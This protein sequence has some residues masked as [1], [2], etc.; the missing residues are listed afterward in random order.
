VE[1]GIDPQQVGDL[2]NSINNGTSPDGNASVQPLVNGWMSQAIAC[3]IDTN[4]LNSLNSDL[5]WAQDQI[6]M[7]RRRQSLAVNMLAQNYSLGS[8][9]GS[10]MVGAGAAGLGRF[11]TIAA[12]EKAG[13]KEAE[14]ANN[15]LIS[16]Q[17]LIRQ[18]E[19]NGN[20]PDYCRALFQSLSLSELLE[21]SGDAAEDDSRAD[22]HALATALATA[23]RNGYRLSDGIEF[24]VLEL[25]VP[26]LSEAT[27]PPQ[28]MA[29]L[30]SY[31]MEP[32]YYPWA[33]EVFNALAADPVASS[34]FLK[35]Y[36]KDIPF[37]LSQ[38]EHSGLPDGIANVFYNVVK[39]GTLGD[40]GIN[41]EL[42]NAAT[43]SLVMAYDAN[44][45]AHS[46]RPQ[47][48]ALYDQIVSANWDS[49]QHAI[50]DPAPVAGPGQINLSA[51][52]WQA[53]IS[54]GMQNS[55]A[56]AHLLAFAVQQAYQLESKNLNNPADLHAA[57]VIQGF[58]GQTAL[59]TY[60]QM[61]S[62]EASGTAA[63][64]T[65][66]SSQLSA[67]ASTG[68]DV[69][70]DPQHAASVVAGDAIKDMASVIAGQWA[71]SSSPP[72]LKPPQIPGWRG[73]WT[74]AAGWEYQA[75][76]N[77]GDPQKYEQ[78][79]CPGRPFLDNS[80]NLVSNANISQREAYNAWLQDPALAQKISTPQ[81]F[82]ATDN[83]RLDGEDEAGKGSS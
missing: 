2:I 75:N 71:G 63:W 65:N 4:R 60:Q 16:Q 15:G 79:Y 78:E 25:L 53:F 40:R 46:V 77:I 82:T 8:A 62:D 5:A 36:S 9:A 51:A 35:Y 44:P 7:L 27:F 45:G 74:N 28:V 57:G 61:V 69:A 49:V 29:Q 43:Q 21:L 6:P 56:G 54:E 10:G 19:E 30:G 66:F 48:D 59:N 72:P 70:L 73:D 80:G 67:A 68:V 31:C 52:Q 12:A 42:A 24:E 3:G 20:D 64:Q 23:M 50:A 41:P 33:D 76:P 13:Q 38:G 14:A 22:Q 32:G 58:F 81:M 83:G 37:F 47:F 17:D 26:L 11:S 34:T 1:V 39:A 18:L 55:T